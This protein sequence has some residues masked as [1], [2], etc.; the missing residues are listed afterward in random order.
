MLSTKAVASIAL[1]LLLSFQAAAAHKGEV[2][3]APEF[4]HSNQSEWINSWPLTMKALKG[5]VLLLDFWTFDCWNCY[6]SFPWLHE[7]EEKYRDQHF[8]VIGIHTPEFEHERKHDQVAEKVKGYGLNHP[9]MVD[10]DFSYWNA[11]GTRYWPTF[12]LIDKQGHIRAT[13]IG[14]THSGDSQAKE[15]EMAIDKLLAE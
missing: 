6:R 14:E 9:V 4:T 15:V 3:L 2:P 1:L 7:I 12:Y 8:L 10:N 13:F 5:K 11:M